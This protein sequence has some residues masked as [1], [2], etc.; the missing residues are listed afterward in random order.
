MK[1][2]LI[3]VVLAICLVMSF[4]TFSVTAAQPEPILPQWTNISG[5]TASLDFN[6]T[7]GNVA[8]VIMGQSGV[9]NITAEVKLYYKNFFGS[10][11][12]ID[13]GWSYNVNQTLLSITESFAGDAGT[14]YKIEV[15]GTVTKNGYVE[16]FSK[17]ATGTCPSSP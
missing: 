5:I 14:E 16:S 8:V 3:S 13:Q 10:W 9:S 2:R 15:S 4:M 11:K 6:G 1:I 12:E 7:T 17:T